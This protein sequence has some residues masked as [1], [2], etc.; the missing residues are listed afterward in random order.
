MQSLNFQ[1]IWYAA[2]VCLVDRSMAIPH[3][4]INNL[5]LIDPEK[6]KEKGIQGVVFDKDN[7]LTE[8]YNLQIHTRVKVSFE[9]FK[10]TFGPEKLAIMSNSAGSSD[11]LKNEYKEAESIESALGIGVIRHDTKK[12]GGI[13]AIREYFGEGIFPVDL[14]CVGDRLL[15]DIAFGN[16]YGML[17]FHTQALTNRGDNR[18]AAYFREWETKR[19]KKWIKEG[20]EAPFHKLYCRDICFLEGS[21]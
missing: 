4:F 18:M 13:D 16:R 12:P 5:T 10:T 8:P 7:T 15:T 6:L 3:Y 20:H 1:G 14:A 2:Y 17:T 9:R 11:D 21:L 19:V